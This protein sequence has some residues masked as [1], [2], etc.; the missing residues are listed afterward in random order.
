MAEPQ[1]QLTG[2]EK[3][4]AKQGP[5]KLL[6]LDSGGIRGLMTLEILA[7]IERTL[8]RLYRQDDH[9]VLADYFDYIGGTSIGA[10]TAMCLSL[11][12]SV[13][14]IREFYLRAAPAMFQKTPWWQRWRNKYRCDRLKAMIKTVIDMVPAEAPE[15]SGELAGT[16]GSAKLRTLLLLVMR[17]ATTDSPWPVSNN[18][19]ARFNCNPD[20]PACNLKLPLWQLVRASAAAPTFFEPEVIRLGPQ[21]F[22]FDDGAMTPFG[23]PA[24]QLF[25]MATA[26]PYGLQWPTGEDRMLLVSVGTGSFSQAHKVAP[27]GEDLLHLAA[28]IPSILIGGSV[29]HQDCLCRIFGNCKAGDPIDAE[30]GDLIGDRGGPVHPKLFTYLRYNADLTREGLAALGLTGIHVAG[31]QRLDACA[32]IQ[33]LQAIGRAVARKQIQAEH[34]SD[35]PP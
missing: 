22:V 1:T 31:I 7:E 17:N 8:R 10:I 26:C 2:V 14:A 34:F 28:R 18:P 27:R 20:D 3:K 13:D 15:K 12:M 5:R 23:N 11:G 24:F 19:R 4:L 25:L 16:L 33:N 32:N 9:F 29:S 6:A 35:F 21:T 30:I